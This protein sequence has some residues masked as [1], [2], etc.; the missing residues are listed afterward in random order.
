MCVCPEGLEEKR[1]TICPSFCFHIDLVLWWLAKCPSIAVLYLAFITVMG[2]AQRQMCT[3]MYPSM[4]SLSELVNY[5]LYNVLSVH[6]FWFIC[7]SFFLCILSILLSL[8][9]CLSLYLSHAHSLSPPQSFNNGINWPILSWLCLLATE[10]HHLCFN[11]VQ[12]QLAALKQH[13]WIMSHFHLVCVRMCVF[14]CVMDYSEEVCVFVW[15]WKGFEFGWWHA[16]VLSTSMTCILKIKIV[17][18]DCFFLT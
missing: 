5:I 9:L 6:L 4:L 17:V 13:S 16:N 8:S 1:L 11:Q 7:I 10:L 14:V 3:R 12:R 15:I 2:G 18:S